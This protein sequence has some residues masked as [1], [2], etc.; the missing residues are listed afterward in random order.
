MPSVPHATLHQYIN[1]VIILNQKKFMKKFFTLI[2]IFIII[3]LKATS[4]SVGIGT[5]TP[6]NSAQL[7]INSTDKGL[8]VPRM[9]AA[10][11]AAIV[12][13]ATGLIVYQTDGSTGFYYNNG[14]PLATTWLLLINSNAVVTSVT[15]S[16]PL[17]SSG[18]NTPNL[19]MPGTSGGVL[20]GTGTGSAFTS[21]G[22]GGANFLKSNGSAPP[23]WSVLG[24]TAETFYGTSSIAVGP[25]PGFVPIPGLAQTINVPVAGLVYVACDGGLSINSSSP[26]SFSITEIALFIDGAPTLNGADRRIIVSNSA[27]L[28]NQIGNWSFSQFADLAPGSHTFQ[29]MAAGTGIGVSATVS[30]DTN[31]LLQGELTIIIVKQ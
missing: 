28:V 14:A 25:G 9:T 24:Q 12:E 2:L 21:A 15:A 8:L 18:G 10:Q 3:S 30:G 17:A 29:I 20:Y 4:Q 19:S 16:S 1:I 13:P 26:T 27:A 6:D 7:H 23:T 11:R 5:T 31:S 22:S